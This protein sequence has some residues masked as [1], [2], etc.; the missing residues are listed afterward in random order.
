VTESVIYLGTGEDCI[1]RYPLFPGN[2]RHSRRKCQP[3]ISRQ[4]SNK[5]TNISLN[6]YLHIITH[7]YACKDVHIHV[8]ILIHVEV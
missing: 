8:F 7:K 1:E 4:L 2:E 5:M 3:M 6:T